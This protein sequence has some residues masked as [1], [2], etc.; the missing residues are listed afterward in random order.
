MGGPTQGVK[1]FTIM[2]ID[3]HTIAGGRITQVHHLEDW[4]TAMKQVS[5]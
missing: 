5:G 3:V 2:T 4:G 1:S